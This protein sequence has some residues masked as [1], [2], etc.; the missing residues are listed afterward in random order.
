[1]KIKIISTSHS[2]QSGT[3]QEQEEFPRDLVEVKEVEKEK[4]PVVVTKVHMQELVVK[5]IGDLKEAKL[6]RKSDS[7]REVSEQ[8][9]LT[10]MNILNKLIWRR[11][12]IILRKE[13]LM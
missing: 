11:L 10:M 4:H 3:I 12:H 2:R 7:L 6:H 9:D 1:M 8:E 5:L 13:I